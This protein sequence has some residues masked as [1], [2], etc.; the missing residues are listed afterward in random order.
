MDLTPTDLPAFLDEHVPRDLQQDLIV[1]CILKGYAEAADE[2]LEK[3][4]AEQ[5]HDVRPHI[6]RAKIEQLL[7][8]LP[9][10]HHQI[11][12]VTD[13]NDSNNAYHVRVNSGR[14]TFTVSAVDSP[15]TVV[16]QAVFRQTLAR[17]YQL[18]FPEM[19]MEQPA[20]DPDALL[21]ALIIHGPHKE[22]RDQRFPAFIC[23][24]F[25]TSDC[26]AYIDRLDLLARFRDLPELKAI[27]AIEQIPDALRI[28]VRETAQTA[29][30]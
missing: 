20:P 29:G 17:R 5:A 16:R 4:A 11:R 23:V 3:Y 6:R 8:G 30:E 21:Y 14:V 2:C 19:G 27:P 10:Q 22:D 25:P 26:S 1:R 18:P 7:A 15:D 28:S 24:V 9:S 12:A 13:T